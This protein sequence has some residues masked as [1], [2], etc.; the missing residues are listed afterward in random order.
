MKLNCK[1]DDLAYI[2]RV[3][4]KANAWMLGQVVRC[5]RMEIMKGRAGWHLEQGVTHRQ[6]IFMWEWV[7]DDCLRPIGNPGDDA[8]DESL[9]W[10]PV[11]GREEVSAC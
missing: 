9:S 4:D 1:K 3:T 7:A 6:T 5:V 8:R 11:P 10:L 2:Y